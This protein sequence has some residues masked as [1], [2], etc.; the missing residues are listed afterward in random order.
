[1]QSWYS[2]SASLGRNRI[3]SREYLFLFV[4]PDANQPICQYCCPSPLR[5]RPWAPGPSR[6]QPGICSKSNQPAAALTVPLTAGQIGG[7][8]DILLPRGSTRRQDSGPQNAPKNRLQC[9]RWSPIYTAREIRRPSCSG[10]CGNRR[11]R[12]AN[13]EP[14]K[15]S[16]RVGTEA[17]KRGRL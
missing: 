15:P 12:I 5:D 9:T 3:L 1:M 7:S 4:N 11:P 8:I 13:G 10:R 6:H 2:A 17:A 16:L 14:R